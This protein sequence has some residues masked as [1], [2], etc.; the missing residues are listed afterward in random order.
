MLRAT[1]EEKKRKKCMSTEAIFRQ[2]GRVND[3][4]TGIGPGKTREEYLKLFSR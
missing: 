3:S 1:P 2:L 4:H